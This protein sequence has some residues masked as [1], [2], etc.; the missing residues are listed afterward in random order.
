MKT[1]YDEIFVVH[2]ANDK[3]RMKN[4]QNQFKYVNLPYTIWWTTKRPFSN[5]IAQLFREYMSDKY[6]ENIFRNGNHNVLGNV[7]NC[8]LAHYDIIKTSFERGLEHILICED[9]IDFI[10]TEENIENVLNMK[11][12]N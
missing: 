5:D 1:F 9:D 6:Y 11:P 10:E 4:I 8:A 12:M 7:F 2:L 3:S